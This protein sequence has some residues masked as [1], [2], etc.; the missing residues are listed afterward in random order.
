[1][2]P[3][4]HATTSKIGVTETSEYFSDRS[5]HATIRNVSSTAS[6]S[7]ISIDLVNAS[8]VL[9]NVIGSPDTLIRS[10]SAPAVA[11]R[12][13]AA[14]ALLARHWPQGARHDAALAL[15]GDADE[16]CII[17]GAEIYGLA[18]PQCDRI[19]LTLVHTVVDAD[20]W[21]ASLEPSE[22]HEVSR[23]DRPADP[24]HAFA[25]SF[26]ELRRTR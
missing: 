12:K 2:Y 25:F 11:V 18:L 24:R 19:H 6:G 14:A 22:W 7:E 5:I 21:F 9:R 16:V 15:A 26:I 17:G 20:T 1:M 3:Y 23:E 13:V 10:I 4:T 8:S